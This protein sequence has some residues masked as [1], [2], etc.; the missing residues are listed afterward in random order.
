MEIM[1]K[2]ISKTVINIPMS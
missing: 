2:F 1:I